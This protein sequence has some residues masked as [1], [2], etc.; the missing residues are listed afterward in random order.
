MA[1]ARHVK[2]GSDTVALCKSYGKDTK[3]LAERH[4]KGTACAEHAMYESALK[5]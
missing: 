2:S 1:W 5:G 3:P 4:G